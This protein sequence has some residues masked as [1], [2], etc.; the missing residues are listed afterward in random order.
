MSKIKKFF[1]KYLFTCF[2][3]FIFIYFPIIYNA[4]WRASVNGE[5]CKVL[6]ANGGFCA[7]Y[8]P[9]G[10]STVSLIYSPA[11]V[12]YGEYLSV[13]A[14]IIILLL[15]IYEGIKNSSQKEKDKSI[16]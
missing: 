1:K 15:L 14:V 5:S 13:G 9:K 2:I 11:G 3:L 4:D 12:R 7:V 6:R 8:V 10:K 16:N